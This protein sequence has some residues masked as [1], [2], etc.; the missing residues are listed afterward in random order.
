MKVY[1]KYGFIFEPEAMWT[2][3]SQFEEDL[4]KFFTDKGFQ[5]ELVETAEGQENIPIIY[6][7]K[8]NLQQSKAEVEFKEE[9]LDGKPAGKSR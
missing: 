5:A 7:K 8:C 4:G 3:K 9:D 1:L 2:T 6:L